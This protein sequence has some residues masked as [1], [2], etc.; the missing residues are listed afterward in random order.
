MKFSFLSWNLRQ[1]RGSAARLQDADQLIT[2]LKPH[3]F[4]LIAKEK[5]T[6]CFLG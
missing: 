4:G 2:R 5:G 1:Y 3:I 6:F